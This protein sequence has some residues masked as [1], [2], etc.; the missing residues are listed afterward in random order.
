MIRVHQVLRF[1]A[2]AL[3]AAAAA[4]CDIGSSL[5][6]ETLEPTPRPPRIVK[7]KEL[8]STDNRTPEPLR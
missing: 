1:A 5:E 2:L 8:K 7:P 3:L 4:G 6:P